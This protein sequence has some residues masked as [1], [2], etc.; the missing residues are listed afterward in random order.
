MVKNIW[1]WTYGNIMHK[2]TCK[3]GCSYHRA[4]PVFTGA[5]PR[6]GE[7]CGCPGR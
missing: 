4:S 6:E 1:L 2:E 3:A 7:Y 5:Y